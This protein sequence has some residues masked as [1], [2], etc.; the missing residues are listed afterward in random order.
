MSGT[1]VITSAKMTRIGMF[2]VKFRE[3]MEVRKKKRRTKL[4][5]KI[6]KTK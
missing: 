4:L 1:R 3:M 6:W 2:T 5:F